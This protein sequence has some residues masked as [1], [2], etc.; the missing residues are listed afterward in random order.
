MWLRLRNVER[1]KKCPFLLLENSRPLSPPREP[2][3]P[4]S[5]GTP[6]LLINLPRNWLSRQHTHKQPMGQKCVCVCL[7]VCTHPIGA[8]VMYTYGGIFVLRNWLMP[9]LQEIL[10]DRECW[11]AAVHGVTK[12][13]RRLSDWTTKL[14]ELARLNSADRAVGWRPR[15]ELML[16][17]RS[18]VEFC[19][20][21]GALVFSSRPSTDWRKPTHILESSTLFRVK[22]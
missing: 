16:Q 5:S 18:G 12:R 14:P 13:Q 11:Y 15:G 4:L 20:L 6:G 10:K 17:P 3:T 21:Q 2:Q 9:L 7:C 19:L 22:C 1:E 8:Y